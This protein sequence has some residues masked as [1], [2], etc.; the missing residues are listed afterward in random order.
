MEEAASEARWETAAQLLRVVLPLPS[1][2]TSPL[3]AAEVLLP[4]T[5]RKPELRGRARGYELHVQGAQTLS[6]TRK[7]PVAVSMVLELVAEDNT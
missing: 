5:L 7:W 4:L 2:S 3:P 1:R 6:R